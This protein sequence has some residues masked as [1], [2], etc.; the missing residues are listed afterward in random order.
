LALKTEALFS[1][2]WGFPA[3]RTN[4]Q[5]VTIS[6]ASHCKLNS[7]P[8]SAALAPPIG[9]LR[10]IL[11]GFLILVLSAAA[12]ALPHG[13]R[14]QDK[15]KL[16]VE[17]DIPVFS[18]AADGRV[19]YAVRHF[20][21]AK[22]YQ[23]QRD[24]IWIATP[25]GKK[26]RIVNGEKV[27]KGN[28]LYSYAIQSF[29]WSPDSR[30]LA[31]QMGTNEVTDDQG[32]TKQGESTEL[33]DDAGRE[34]E[35]ADTHTGNIPDA[36]QAAWLADDA[37]VAYLTE[38]IKPRE[39]FAINTVRPLAGH[40]EPVFVPHTFNAV[41]WDVRRNAAVAIEHN[42]K[43]GG[44]FVLVW[45]DLIKQTRRE[46]AII[47][48]FFGQLTISPSGERVAYFS[49]GDT[50][51]IRSVSAPDK[52]VRIRVSYG[53]YEWAPGEQRL[54]IKRGNEHRSG[55]LTWL[56]IPGGDLVPALH[57]QV[58][59]EFH[60]SPTGQWLGVLDPGKQGFQIYPLRAE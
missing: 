48:G 5:G 40:A 13:A 58:F 3:L 46:L 51:E 32:S 9:G 23:L 52:A 34:I 4:S 33:L 56:S 54:L 24:D 29:A 31:V 25:E 20:L 43:L 1:S 27:I 30:R 19:A 10:R 44:P 37:T 41:A 28:G 6:L 11:I 35:I 12:L 8:V 59:R 22:H 55:D 7:T 50:L 26:T 2:E 49:D 17:D 60:I 42:T 39:L 36:F 18:I 38:I 14:A 45:L 21:K 15:P 16:V 53:R 47:D 57:G